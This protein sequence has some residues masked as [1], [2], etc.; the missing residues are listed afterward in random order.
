MAF[1]ERSGYRRMH[2]NLVVIGE[3]VPDKERFR[4]NLGSLLDAIRGFLARAG[5]NDLLRICV[6]A[7]TQVEQEARCFAHRHAIP[8]YVVTP[9]LPSG[10]DAMQAPEVVADVLFDGQED[11][12]AAT[13]RDMTG[14]SLLCLADALIVV[15]D[16]RIEGAV[17]DVIVEAM[18]RCVPIFWIDSG[19]AAV[20][21]GR[22]LDYVRLPAKAL[23]AIQRCGLMPHGVTLAD[24]FGDVV[25]ASSVGEFL[26]PTWS[27]A[28][29]EAL[30]TLLG[31]HEIDPKTGGTWWGTAHSHFFAL[32]G[33][34]WS[35]KWYA[36]VRAWRS[37]S[38][39]WQTAETEADYPWSCFDR[40]DRAATHAANRHRDQVVLIYLLASLAVGAAIAGSIE[41][42]GLHALAWAGFELVLIMMVGLLVL[43][44]RG[45]AS[46]NHLRWLNFRQA[47]EALRVSFVL[48][49]VMA[50]LNSL[51]HGIWRPKWSHGE[52]AAGQLVL[53]KPFH[54][55]V[56]NLLRD[57]PFRQRPSLQCRADDIISRLRAL[58]EDQI[59]F[60]HKNARRSEH[61]HHPLH[62][63]VE[64]IFF[65]VLVTV[66]IHF[67]AA[68]LLLLPEGVLPER[69][70]EAGEWFHHQ[71]WPLMITGFLPALAAALHGIDSK[72]E[73]MRIVKGSEAMSEKLSAYLDSLSLLESSSMPSPARALAV[74]T[75][76]I[77]VAEA[78]YEEHDAWASLMAVQQIE[79]PA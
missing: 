58:L 48:Q 36:P 71:A 11:V 33:G 41:F 56:M 68:I 40:F 54:W 31:E 42:L 32:L 22:G 29:L 23:Q 13:L 78:M 15:W 64:L 45:G 25:C 26:E 12:S 9:R 46:S 35:R 67:L 16:G 3:D 73:L 60:H 66:C 21:G 79:I 34:A 38:A 49:L 6:G 77:S 14:E 70:F 61:T 74:R 18:R 52:G 20:D 4:A 62:R 10:D 47:A 75:L 30:N 72:I 65:G 39:Y 17:T 27:V 24:C 76:A 7:A 53:A 28:P 43:S 1:V 63:L 55:L 57:M 8:C 50:S 69:L 5:R 37:V 59:E 51:H 19:P 2:R 44:S